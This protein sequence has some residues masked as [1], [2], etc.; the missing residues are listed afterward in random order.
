MSHFLVS[1]LILLWTWSLPL[2]R[3]RVSEIVA[4]FVMF[5]PFLSLRLFQRTRSDKFKELIVWPRSLHFLSFFL[6]FLV[7]S[8]PE[9]TVGQIQRA[10]C[11][12]PIVLSFHL[13]GVVVAPTEAG[14]S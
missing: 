4:I 2:R 1:R 13:V 7:P 5:F 3:G 8:L 10:D 12:A 6:I 11:L 14:A 9:N